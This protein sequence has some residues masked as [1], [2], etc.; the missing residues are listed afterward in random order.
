MRRTYL[1]ASALVKLVIRLRGLLGWGALII[2]GVFVL[3]LFSKGAGPMLRE[4]DAANLFQNL[5][6]K[7]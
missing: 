2:T 1:D 5:H 4:F 7:Y 3:I 6:T